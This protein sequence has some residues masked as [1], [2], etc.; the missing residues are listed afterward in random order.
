MKAIIDVARRGTVFET[1]AQQL[2]AGR[3]SDY[4]LHFESAH[5]LFAQLTPARIDLLDTLRPLGKCSV[6]ALAKAASRN[7]YNVQ[8]EMVALEKL[9]LVKRSPGGT[10]HVPFEAL[11]IRLSLI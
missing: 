11:E 2:A 1:A 4:R 7:H 5:A 8:A 6:Y 10:V 9:G 3:A